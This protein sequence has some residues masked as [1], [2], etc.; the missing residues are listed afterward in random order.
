[1]EHFDTN[2]WQLSGRNNSM[3][4]LDNDEH[5]VLEISINDPSPSYLL[6]RRKNT[7]FRE[8][9]ENSSIK[10][11]ADRWVSVTALIEGPH[12]A[13]PRLGISTYEKGG[14][15][16]VR[17]I[18]H[19][20]TESTVSAEL[21][22][23]TV[24]AAIYCRFDMPGTYL[25]KMFDV[26][27]PRLRIEARQSCST[28]VQIPEGTNTLQIYFEAFSHPKGPSSALITVAWQDNSGNALTGVADH[29]INSSF[30]P[31]VYINKNG[32]NDIAFGIP[33]NATRANIQLVPWKSG[34]PIFISEQIRVEFANLQEEQIESDSEKIHSVLAAVPDNE[35]LI[36][37]HTTAPPLGHS[38]LSL[39]PNRLAAEFEKLGYHVIFMPFSVIDEGVIQHSPKSWIICRSLWPILQLELARRRGINNFYVCTSF[40]NF[41][42]LSALDLLNLSGWIT[43][44]EVRDDMEE[45][46][47]VGYSKWFDIQLER[48]VARRAQK[49]LAVSPRLAQKANLIAG[50]SDAIVSPN[51]VS[52]F[53]FEAG[54]EYRT[55]KHQASKS[56]GRTI[57]YLGHLTDSWF[58]WRLVLNV[59][60]E[61]SDYE[62]RIV[63][64]GIPERVEMVLPNNVKYLGPMTHEE[65][66]KEA[67]GWNVG[68]IPFKISPLTFGVDPNKLY[69]Y[70]ALGVPVVSAPM[71]SVDTAPFTRVYRTQ[72]ELSKAISEQ[73]LTI[74]TAEDMQLLENYLCKS[75]WD[76]R[77]QQV[78]NI[79][80]EGIK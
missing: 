56:N 80:E 67:G 21:L 26:Q 17:Q 12:G 33:K 71:G 43:V 69:E 15:S 46:N 10:I 54:R 42:A 68:L 65:F 30:G 75:R 39:R 38:T 5:N 16:S 35:G 44:Y 22:H 47:R 49:V 13:K 48:H 29:A 51:A 8:M 78:I 50:R 25:V 63:G 52:D 61:L 55:L 40:P 74:F 73:V 20:G 45:F 9:D 2:D 60:R 31:Y 53:L 4:L 37:L 77:A 36:V 1:M 57:G 28:K 18:K 19:W 58:D 64:H 32:P 41:E 34:A 66:V 76:Y 3:R 7:N 62:F 79:L 6:Y 72:D 23:G 14:E 27:M 24:S 70:L 11:I 59:A